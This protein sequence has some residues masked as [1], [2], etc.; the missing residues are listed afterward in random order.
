MTQ[1][2]FNDVDEASDGKNSLAKIHEQKYGLVISYLNMVPMNGQALLQH[3]RA[4]KHF[5][6]LHFI[7]MTAES[8]VSKVVDAKHAGVDSFINKPFD[9]ETLKGKISSIVTKIFD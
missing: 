6:N 2:G 3:V 4:E 1:L 7:M 8:A 5:A 9:A